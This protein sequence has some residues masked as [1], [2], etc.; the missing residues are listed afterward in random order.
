MNLSAEGVQDLPNPVRE[1]G[2]NGAD[3]LKLWQ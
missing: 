3:I 1:V 2:G